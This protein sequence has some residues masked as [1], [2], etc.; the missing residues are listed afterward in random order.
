MLP[1]ITVQKDPN[2][3]TSY[4]YTPTSISKI[5]MI[6]LHYDIKIKHLSSHFTWGV[7][8]S[9]T[10][11]EKIFLLTK[12]SLKCVMTGS[13]LL[14][15]FFFHPLSKEVDVVNVEEDVPDDEFDIDSDDESG[16]QDDE[17]FQ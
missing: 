11:E 3:S 12:L 5:N 15:V 9:F 2:R 17:Q 10:W 4:S 8:E 6:Y 14:P 7:S 16:C 13:N 1:Y